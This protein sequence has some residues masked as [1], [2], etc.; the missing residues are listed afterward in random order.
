MG[1]TPIQE[2]VSGLFV[3]LQGN[4]TQVQQ[5]DMNGVLTLDL[6]RGGTHNLVVH[7]R[8]GRPGRIR[9]GYM[10]QRKLKTGFT[11]DVEDGRGVI[12]TFV[13]LQATGTLI[14][15]WDEQPHATILVRVQ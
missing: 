6:R 1:T 8:S 7:N 13:P 14:L 5:D 4:N 9:A 2:P 10:E 11:T 3:S 15:G 12:L